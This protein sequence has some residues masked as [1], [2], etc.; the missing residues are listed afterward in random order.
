MKRFVLAI[1]L[2]VLCVA[3]HAQEYRGTI[4]G[5]VNDPSGAVIPNA[6]VKATNNATN[7][8]SETKTNSDGVYTLPLLSPVYTAWKRERPVFRL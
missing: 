1:L 4:T 8:V 6:T 7:N 5:T 2:A 3:L